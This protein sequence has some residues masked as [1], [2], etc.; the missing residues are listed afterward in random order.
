MKKEAV[1]ALILTLVLVVVLLSQIEI[2]NLIEFISSISPRWILLAF[3][4]Y[5]FTVIF[6]ALR[7]QVLLGGGQ[8]IRFEDIF[9]IV[10]VHYLFSNILPARTRELSY[11]YLLKKLKKISVGKGIATLMVA[12]IFDF[13]VVAIFFLISALFVKDLPVFVSN[14]IL[15]LTLFLFIL[16]LLLIFLL[17]KNIK[18]LKI[19]EKATEKL[20]IQNFKI[21]EFLMD[22]LEDI[23]KSLRMIPRKNI[24]CSFALSFFVWGCFF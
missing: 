3:V 19:L 6:R 21:V 13:I 16:I 17:Y 12:R 20:G 18:F 9:P 7:F 1:F 10:C 4:I 8:G 14:A 11:I 23:A 22:K 2:K 15:P 5:I 24:L